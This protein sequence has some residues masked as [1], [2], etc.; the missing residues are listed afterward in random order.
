[1]ALLG[2]TSGSKAA[3]AAWF[4][5]ALSPPQDG[6]IAI[7]FAVQSALANAQLQ[8]TVNNRTDWVAFGTSGVALAA[9]AGYELK[10]NISKASQFNLRQTT[11]AHPAGL[12]TRNIS[13]SHAGRRLSMLKRR[14]ISSES[15]C[16]S[17]KGRA[18]TIIR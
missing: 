8:Y 6:E 18:A 17:P 15:A 4:A 16:P 13:R 14:A 12:P 11:T 1:M 5:T 3:N 7:H 9:N 2:Q 10:L